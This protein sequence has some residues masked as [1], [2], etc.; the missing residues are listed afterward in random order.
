MKN[1]LGVIGSPRELGNCELLVKEIAARIPGGAD[2]SMVRL[3]GKDIRACKACYRCL[4][5][6]CPHPDDFR[7]V[8]EAILSADGVIVAAP[9]YSHGAHSSLQ[10]FL[11]RGLQ[12][13][14]HVKALEKKAAVAVAV[15][16]VEDGQGSA[17]LGVENFIKSLGMRVKDRALVHAALPGE[18]LLSE[19]GKRAAE[20][21]AASLFGDPRPAKGPHCPVCGGTYFEFQGGARV[22]CLLCGAS[23]FASI[24]GAGSRI[25][26]TPPAHAWMDARAL[27][28]HGRWLAGM[29]DRF[30][31]ER[32]R[33][34]AVAFPHRG[35]RF[36]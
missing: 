1:V 27:E 2:L 30:L 19:D 20:R 28:E 23:G 11:D 10:R 9:A 24:D 7:P 31:R 8:L 33:L 16:G 12:F 14:A 4:S 6:A 29:K 22:Y 35:G 13:I 5:G 25:D 3:A 21:L 15:A 17:L 32:D 34:R 18:V 26:T 36:L